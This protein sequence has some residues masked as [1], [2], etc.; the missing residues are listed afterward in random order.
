MTTAR[1]D[2]PRSVVLTGLRQERDFHRG[3]SKVGRKVLVQAEAKQVD[4]RPGT[5]GVAELDDLFSIG[6]EAIPGGVEP[7]ARAG[8][9]PTDR[10]ASIEKWSVRSTEHFPHLG[11]E[12][13]QDGPTYG[14]L[15]SSQLFLR[16]F[17]AQDQATRL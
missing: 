13:Q 6:D 5:K 12:G 10:D 17:Q 9:G 8:M 2:F 11:L 14:W 15:S 3:S 1:P 4:L 7:A 16:W